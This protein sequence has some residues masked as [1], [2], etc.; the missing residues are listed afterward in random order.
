MAPG[1]RTFSGLAGVVIVVAV[2]VVGVD[3]AFSAAVPPPRYPEVEDG[4]AALQ[5]NDPT[6][7]VLGSSHL[8]TFDAVAR[9][10]DRRTAG[11]RR[12]VSIPVDW[13]K[14]SSYRWTW[15][16]RVR[17]ILDEVDGAKTGTGT[18]PSLRQVIL[19]T[20]WWDFRVMGPDDDPL[21]NLPA[22]S[23]D[24]LDWLE[25]VWR[26]GVTP[27]NQN[28]VLHRWTRLFHG[29]SLVQFRG[30][31]VLLDWL[32]GVL[33]P[34]SARESMETRYKDRLGHFR[35]YVQRG[36]ERLFDPGDVQSFDALLDDFRSR[37]LDV[38]V[39]LFP[40][41][42]GMLTDRARESPI[43]RF[44]EWMSLRC[45]QRGVRL[46][47]L[48]W[49]HPLADPDFGMDLDHPTDD[50]NRRF[51]PWILDSA[52]GFLAGDVAELDGNGGKTP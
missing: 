22:R 17:P 10:L 19:V 33:S 21:V 45:R 42:H 29:S 44:S 3:L 24:F 13:G 2:L 37:G 1:A 6:V 46:V 9:E 18:I 15:E 5:S 51:A 14:M 31:T 7:L 32:K 16:H 20:Q 26:E 34:E 49:D 52:L 38:T 41:M 8:R 47:D 48:S 12:M 30:R 43:G 35:E 23:W 28:Y 36:G 27:Y 11:V 4:L 25:D 50:A 40:R 39:L